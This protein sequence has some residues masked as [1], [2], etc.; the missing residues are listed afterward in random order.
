LTGG[1]I[2]AKE[3]IVSTLGTAYSLGAVDPDQSSSLKDRLIR[4]PNWNAVVA[5][6]FLAFIMFYA[7]CL[8]TVVCIAKEAGSWKWA[9]FS[10]VFNTALAFLM[11]VAIYQG[12]IALGIG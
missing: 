10:I 8:V 9:L 4:D 12:G 1:P 5:L 6:A 2:A 3:V 11:A 7:P